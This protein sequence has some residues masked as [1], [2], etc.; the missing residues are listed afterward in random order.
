MGIFKSIQVFGLVFPAFLVVLA[1][2]QSEAQDT[3]ESKSQNVIVSPLVGTWVTGPQTEITIELCEEGF[4]GYIT[5]V[6]VPEHIKQRF[7]EAEIG[8]LAPEEY[9]DFLN[10]DP[11]LRDRPILGLQIL[12]LISQSGPARYDGEIYNPEDGKTY[13]GYMEIVGPDR[14]RLTGCAVF[15]L[16]C[17]GE[18]WVRAPQ[19]TTTED[20][21]SEETEM[22]AS[23]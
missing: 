1:P 17:R 14:V 5:K 19:V 21:P 20:P 7:G 3:V 6:V 11:E 15:N 2:D 16:V 4:C 13:D 12:T 23:E 9:F 10:E 22:P 18:E 8:E